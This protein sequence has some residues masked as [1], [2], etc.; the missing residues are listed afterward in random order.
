MK[1]LIMGAGA[2]G[3]VIGGFLAKNGENVTLVGREPHIQAIKNGGLRIDGIWGNQLIAQEEFA[4]L[5]TKP[6]PDNYDYVLITVKAYDTIGV[7]QQLKSTFKKEHP[8]YV[9]MQNGIRNIE[10]L[11][12]KLG[13]NNVAGARVIFGAKIKNPGCVTVT[14]IAEPIAIGPANNN[15]VPEVKE[16]LKKLSEIINSSGIPSKYVYNVQPY[17]WAKVFY[18]SALNPLSALL[19]RTYGELAENPFTKSIM[20]SVIDEAFAVAKRMK[21][22]LFWKNSR[23]YRRHFYNKLIPP[24]ANHYASMLGDL[25]KKRTE[26]DSINGAIVRYGKKL[27]VKTPVNEALTNIIKSLC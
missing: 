12:K 26:I 13:R 16:K 18:N 24:T 5:F 25:K 6:V 10:I 4:G 8:L 1:F 3:S 23:E 17:L 19:N 21:I 22:K 27:K 7:A 11:E 2:I 15:S 9:S 14:V 20:D